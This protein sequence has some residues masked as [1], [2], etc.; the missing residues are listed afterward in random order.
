MAHGV[1]TYLSSSKIISKLKLGQN[2][3]TITLLLK[4]VKSKQQKTCKGHGRR[5]RTIIIEVTHT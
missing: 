4:E 2:K 1:H 3:V 5:V